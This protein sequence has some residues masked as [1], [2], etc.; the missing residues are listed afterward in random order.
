MSK[1]ISNV[2]LTAGALAAAALLLLALS[3]ISGPTSN[4][5]NMSNATPQEQ[6]AP[7]AAPANDPNGPLKRTA[8]GLSYVDQAIG[9]GPAPRPGGTVIVHYEGFLDDGTKFDSSRDRG[10]P[11]EF[12]LNG[13]IKGFSEGLSTM[14]VGGRRTLLIP[15]QLGYG[16]KGAPPAIPPNANLRFEVELVGVK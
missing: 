4:N 5:T 10:Q 16:A 15:P 14:K 2:W 9:S 13:V 6:P 3:S 12:P 8:S 7:A 1:Q 11:A